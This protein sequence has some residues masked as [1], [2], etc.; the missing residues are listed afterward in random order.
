M[1]TTMPTLT[2]LEHK[3]LTELCHQLS[4]WRDGEPGY[5]CIDGSDIT[6]SLKLKPKVV[7][8]VISSLCKK[9]LVWSDD[10]GDFD[11]ILYACWDKID[12]DYARED[13]Q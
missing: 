7:S 6:S 1:K 9:G 4:I 3:V 11:G 5:S 12:T 10:G 13:A 8:G 2:E